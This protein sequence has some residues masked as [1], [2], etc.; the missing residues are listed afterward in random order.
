MWSPSVADFTFPSPMLFATRQS[1]TRGHFLQYG[2]VTDLY[3]FEI[4]ISAQRFR[5]VCAVWY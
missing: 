4:Y 3:T 1:A 2:D 5:T